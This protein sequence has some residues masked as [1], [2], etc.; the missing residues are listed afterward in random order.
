MHDIVQIIQF[1]RKGI[2]LD[3][4]E[5]FHIHKESAANNHLNDVHTTP[6][7]RIFDTILNDLQEENQ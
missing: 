7:N 3:K 1:Q 5:R 4:I 2:H 6:A